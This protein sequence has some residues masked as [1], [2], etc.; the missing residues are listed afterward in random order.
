VAKAKPPQARE[1]VDRLAASPTWNK[2]EAVRVARAALGDTKV[3]SEFLTLATKADA[4]SDGKALAAA[5]ATL[6]LVGTPASLKAI[7]GRLRTP[8]TIELKGAYI[9]SVRLSVL[10]ALLYNFP[11]QPV[12]YPNRILTERDYLAAEQFCV[13]TL[14]TAYNTPEPPFLTYYGYPIPVPQ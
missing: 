13:Q 12:L 9:K 10:E 4:A 8:L 6:G 7:A 5:L 14:G 11:D 3:E 1:L 2:T